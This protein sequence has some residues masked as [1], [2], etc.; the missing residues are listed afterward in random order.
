MCLLVVRVNKALLLLLLA[1]SQKHGF[2]VALDTIICQIETSRNNSEQ[3]STWS[4][5]F[6]HKAR[7]WHKFDEQKVWNWLWRHD[8]LLST[9]INHGVAHF[10]Y[11]L[12]PRM[13]RERQYILTLTRAVTNKFS[14]F[15][16]FIFNAYNKADYLTIVLRKKHRSLQFA[17]QSCSE[18][19]TSRWLDAKRSAVQYHHLCN[20][21]KL[22]P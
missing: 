8:G 10:V 7:K 17:P 22:S 19:R 6:D 21:P 13:T 12:A 5:Q 15:K 1:F 18:Q 11:H 20:C 14:S 2:A 4:K 9:V 16:H 3:V